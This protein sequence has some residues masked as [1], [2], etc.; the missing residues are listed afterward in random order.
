MQTSATRTSA[1]EAEERLRKELAVIEDKDFPGYFLI[2]H[3]MVKY[4]RENG[5]LCQGRGQ[6]PIRLSAT[7]LA[8]PRSIPS[9]SSCP[10]SASC[11]PLETKSRT[12]TSTSTL[13]GVRR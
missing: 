5:I 9:P 1:T 13:T 3:D 12:S 7:S 2:V 6:Q 10:S 8:S 11:R 4:A